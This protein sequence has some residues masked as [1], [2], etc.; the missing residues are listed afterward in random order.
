MLIKSFLETAIND[1]FSRNLYHKA[2]FKWHVLQDR[3]FEDPG[4]PPYYPPAF[5]SLIR[6][7]SMEGTHNLS[8]MTS[9]QLYKIL[10]GINITTEFSDLG[11]REKRQMKPEKLYPEVDWKDHWNILKTK[12]IS[13]NQRSFIFKILHNILPTKSR[14]FR[15]NLSDS[16]LCPLCVHG[17][18]EDLVHSL[19]LCDYNSVINDWIIAVLFDLDPSLVLCEF[20]S[21]DIMLFNLQTEPEKR[22]PIVFFL[23]SVFFIIWQKRQSR[24]PIL[25]TEV[26][27]SLKA[28][29]SIWKESKYNSAAELIEHAL[30]F[31]L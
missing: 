1:K 7:I 8:S 30:N 2:L 9:S 27:S 17:E 5:F 16:P 13:S 14:L 20:S 15:M 12:G 28:E 18:T 26:T 25:L 11:A 23:A 10:L 3:T 19:L 6:Q 22:L 4:S 24:K 31:V 29:V 21:I